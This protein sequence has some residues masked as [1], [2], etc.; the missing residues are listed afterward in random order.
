M[1]IMGIGNPLIDLIFQVKD[2]DLEILGLEKGIMHLVDDPV[3][4]R[5]LAHLRH[6]EPVMAPGGDVPNTMISL[7]L[8]GRHSCFSG[9]VGDDSYGE[10][11]RQRIEACGVHSALRSA[12]GRTGSSIIL[13]SPDGERTMNTYL[14]MC[15]EY[16]SGD[17]DRQAFMEADLL[18]F[19][20]YLWDTEKQKEAV[21]AAIAL[22]EA[23]DHLVAFDLADPFAVQRS[24]QDFLWLL[25][26][27]V[28]LVFAN[29]E[30]AR[31]MTGLGDLGQA[32]LK[33][34]SLV[35]GLAVVKDGARGSVI[36]RGG[37]ILRVA[38]SPATVVDSTGAGDTYA[39]GFIHGL[40]GFMEAEG[41]APVEL[42]DGELEECGR[43]AGFLASRVIGRTGAQL[44][45]KEAP[46]LLDHLARGLHRGAL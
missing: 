9:K 41:Q 10:Q 36:C 46:E 21:N 8:L 11:Y 25:E 26:H 4:D 42:S 19:S 17:L 23:S 37:K 15:R 20:G 18:Y 34:A 33:L 3:R 2:S 14:G 29:A 13:V 32:A 35:E 12:P 7:A 31:L 40:V 27:H 6:K 22:A 39:A 30:E 1:K 5:I 16:G 24:R 43:I 45:P 44:D 28:D 38:A